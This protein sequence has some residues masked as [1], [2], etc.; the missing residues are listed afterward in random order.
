MLDILIRAGS[1]VAIIVLGYVLKRVGFFKEEDFALLS[2][3]T[4]RITLPAAIVSSFAGKQIDPSLL[5]LSLLGF[6]GGVL[7]MAVAF[8]VN[9]RS[10]REK[11]AF[12]VLNLPGY[13]IGTFTL[14]FAQ[15][16]LGSAGVIVTSLFDT[17]NAF[18]CLGGA[19]GI[20]SM[21]KDGS[22]FSCKRLVK[23]LLTSIPFMCHVLMVALN[24][25]RVTI[26]APVVSFAGIIGNANAFMAMLM[27]GV[28]FKLSGDRSQIGTIVKILLLRYGI[29]AVLAVVFYFLLP[30]EL[31]VRQALVIL[32][33]S[34]IGSAVPPFTAE[35]KGD[36][37][38]SSAINS[39][40]I[41]CSIVIIVTLLSVMLY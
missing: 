15:S 40:G 38:L 3:I 18:V 39:I 9:L 31:A 11:R 23:K 13:N 7:Y 25:A 21:I 19:F 2:K 4:I 33:F 37:G 36:V 28:G 8:L 10:S 6:G 20:A 30:F 24:L 32:V 12:E 26:P 1:F 41:I 14:P 22:G 35:L 5:T 34:P 16:F 17:G 29:A 27:I